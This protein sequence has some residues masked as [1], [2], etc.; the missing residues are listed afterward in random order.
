MDADKTVGATF[1]KDLSDSDSDGLTAYDEVV[2]YG[3]NPA[4]ADTDGDGLSDAY[5]LGVGRFSIITGSFTWQ[6][7]RTN[8]QSRGG[9][10]ASFPTEDRWNRALQ[11]LVANPFEDFTGLWI[12]A[13]DAAVDG[14][15]TWVNGES[16]IFAPWGTG[17]PSSTT[18]NS[19]DFAELSGGGGAEIGKWYDRSSTTIREGYLLEI[20]YATN[21]LVADVD[22]DGLNDGQEQTAGTNP[23]IADTDGDG[24]SDGQEV[25]VTK[26]NPKLADSNGDGTN[27]ANSDQDGDGLSNLAEVT[28]YGTD[29]MKADTDGD[30]LRDDFEIGFGRFALISTRLTWNQAKADA[31][32]RGGHLATFTNS[33]EYER[34]RTNIGITSLDSIDGAWV[35]A[36]DEAIDGTW[37]WANGEQSGNFSIPW[38]TGRP[39]NLN[40][41]TLDYAEIS[42][43]DGAEVWKWYDR[44]ATSTRAAYILETGFPT[45]PL[46]ADTDGDGIADGL[47]T[48]SG[49]IPTMA[50]MDADGWNDGAEQDFGGNPR[51]ANVTPNF[52]C[53]L[54]KDS[55]GNQW[56]L[57]FPAAQGQ[58]YTIEASENLSSW[59]SLESNITGNGSIVTRAYP[60]APTQPKRYFR[61][62]RN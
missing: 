57:R 38:G 49:L 6:Q 10:L 18:G 45:N 47:E 37:Q 34:M 50:D 51:S 8:A 52:Q 9:D 22:A 1:E 16:F 3:T 24:L 23:K 29:P 43:G 54:N 62:K 55:T 20:G 33:A 42:G 15:W 26:T 46:V 60:V 25:N 19:L 17:R 48:S 12:G 14:T 7:A 31:A 4:L 27:D 53:K 56:I 41:N 28:E 21:P 40:G 30:G 2:T 11:N 39:S 32:T 13:S 59:N 36:T 58:V 35:G 61:I 44:W 5:E